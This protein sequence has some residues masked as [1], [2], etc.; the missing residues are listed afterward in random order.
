MPNISLESQLAQ[1]Y[2]FHASLLAVKLLFLSPLI[3]MTWVKKGLFSNPDLVRRAYLT[4][5]KNL[6][7]FWMV[8]ALYVT[9]CPPAK[10]ATTLFRAYTSSRLMVT[11]GY[12]LTPLSAAPITDAALL[13]SYLISC[14]M[15]L[16]VMYFYR[17][18]L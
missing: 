13:V 7:P 10:F 12:G 15:S 2:M 14:Y 8:G 18:Y 17:N 11:L 3:S 16:W 4:E 5:L 9:T 1:T 6:A